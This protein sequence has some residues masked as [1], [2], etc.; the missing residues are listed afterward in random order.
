MGVA[1]AEAA[2]GEVKFRSAAELRE[3]LDELFNR[4]DT[5][6]RIGPVLRA[7]RIRARLELTDPGL[8]VNLASAGDEECCLVWSFDEPPPWRPRVTLKM[9]AEVANRWLQGR[10]SLAIAIAR[11]R[12]RCSCE[13]RAALLLLP[14]AQLFV[15]PYKRLLAASHRHLLLD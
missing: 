13:P 5:D 9:G 4:L 15:E 10:E 3:V 1:T 12:A 8:Q 2:T 6:E 11:Q 7:A 14:A